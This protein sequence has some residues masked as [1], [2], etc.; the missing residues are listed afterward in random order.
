MKFIGKILILLP[1][2]YLLYVLTS[3]SWDI[4]FYAFWG[5]VLLGL[6]GILF[7]INLILSCLYVMLG[8]GL[9][10]YFY[11]P[12]IFNLWPMGGLFFLIGSALGAEKLTAVGVQSEEKVINNNEVI[13]KNVE[14]GVENG[15]DFKIKLKPKKKVIKEVER[16]DSRVEQINNIMDRVC[17]RV[18]RVDRE[19]DWSKYE[20]QS[21]LIKLKKKFNKLLVGK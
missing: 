2:Y 17:S 19:F 18:S 21:L 4:T 5:L 8:F 13:K 11:D 15:V 10:C 6:I 20:N 12:N 9:Y 1:F 14:N 7:N 3:H 16:V